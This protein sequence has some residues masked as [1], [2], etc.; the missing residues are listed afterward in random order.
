M[1]T[2][3]KVDRNGEGKTGQLY[4]I[5]EDQTVN[6]YSVMHFI[7]TNFYKQTCIFTNDLYTYI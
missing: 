1:Y 7:S 3:K 4:I 5:F 6:V 2:N